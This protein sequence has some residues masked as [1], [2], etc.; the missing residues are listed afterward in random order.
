MKLI[1]YSF[2]LLALVGL[3]TLFSCGGSSSSAPPPPSLAAQIS[4]TWRIQ[5]F[6][7]LSGT[8]WAAVPG[9][10]VANFRLTINQANDALTTYSITLGALTQD[11][12]PAYL[13][14]VTG[15]VI[16]GNIAF[17]QNNTGL[18][19]NSGSA[20]AVTVDFFDPNPTPTGSNLTLRWTVPQTVNKF[21]PTYRMQL[22][23]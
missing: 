13:G 3:V 17:T 14:T 12:V 1:K 20:N 16:S 23:R 7:Q 15:G 6:E 4:G 2:A 22:V 10:N 9:A 5:A 8:T 19:F 11:Q 21:A 18:I